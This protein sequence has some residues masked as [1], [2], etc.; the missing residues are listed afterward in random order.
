MSRFTICVDGRYY[1]GE[2]EDTERRE[3]PGLQCGWH[4][5]RC[6]PGTEVN[7]LLFSDEPTH[8]CC[9]HVNLFGDLRRIFDR[10]RV[11][12]V[13]VR[14][15]TSPGE[16]RDDLERAYASAEYARREV[17][18]RAEALRKALEEVA[19]IYAKTPADDFALAAHYLA[20]GEVAVAAI[21]GDSK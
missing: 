2:S 6:S 18:A 7:K 20:M 15:A 5:S 9:G 16:S 19:S 8:V 13:V 1:A 11:G 21:K 12:T 4:G 3:A 10:C 17:V 14:N